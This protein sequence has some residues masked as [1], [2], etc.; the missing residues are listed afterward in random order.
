MF[1]IDV[2]Y[3]LACDV[4]RTWVFFTEDELEGFLEE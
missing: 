4:D 2:R 1:E 3:Q